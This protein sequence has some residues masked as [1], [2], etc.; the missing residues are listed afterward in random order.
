MNVQLEVRFQ[1]M[2]TGRRP[3]RLIGRRFGADRRKYFAV[4][5][6]MTFWYLLPQDVVMARKR[7]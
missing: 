2:T 1:Y 6:M 5:H 3:V 4:G 7:L